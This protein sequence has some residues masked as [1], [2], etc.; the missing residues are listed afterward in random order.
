MIMHMVPRTRSCTGSS[1]V[2]PLFR[3]RPPLCWID[4]AL[5]AAPKN[6]PREARLPYRGYRTLLLSRHVVVWV[7]KVLWSL[8]PPLV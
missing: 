2:R 1:R 5:Q 4:V 3:H 6:R 7:R 8:A